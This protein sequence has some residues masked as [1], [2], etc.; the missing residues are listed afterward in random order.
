MHAAPDGKTL[1]STE[2][3]GLIRRWMPSR[4]AEIPDLGNYQ[5]RACAIYSANGLFAAVTDHRGRVDLW[6]MRTVKLLPRC[7]ATVPLLSCLAFTSD[8]KI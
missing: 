6:D 5:G 3:S 8:W 7:R 1:V 4:S 2:S